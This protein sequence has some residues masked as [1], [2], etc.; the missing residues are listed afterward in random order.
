[1][2]TQRGRPR[3]VDAKNL[4]TVDDAVIKLKQRLMERFQDENIVARLAKA[5]GTLYNMISEKRIHRYG[6]PSCALIDIEELFK[7][8]S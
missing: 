1:M 4:C 5:K 7:I 3:E 8:C 2:K 6:T